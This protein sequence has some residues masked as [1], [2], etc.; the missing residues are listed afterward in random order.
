MPCRFVKKG[1][2]I[3]FNNKNTKVNF[4]LFR[5]L[6]NYKLFSFPLLPP[7]ADFIALIQRLTL[8]FFYSINEV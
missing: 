1:L 6:F 4:E 7:Y 2:L 3:Y 5:A 8:D